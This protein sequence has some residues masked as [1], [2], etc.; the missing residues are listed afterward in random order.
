[1]ADRLNQ[2]EHLG[3]ALHRKRLKRVAGAVIG[4]IVAI[5]GNA[6]LLR[7][8]IGQCGNV[9]SHFALTD[10]GTHFVENLVQQRLHGGSWR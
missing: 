3:N 9:V 1:M 4:A 6:Q 8:H 2:A 10:Q 5:H 7:R